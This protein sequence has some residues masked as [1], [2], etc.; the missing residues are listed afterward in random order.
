MAYADPKSIKSCHP[1]PIGL[2][3][4]HSMDGFNV[5]SQE[6]RMVYIHVLKTGGSTVKRS[7]F[8][9]DA[10]AHHPVGG[11]LL[12]ADVWNAEER[13]MDS[14]LTVVSRSCDHL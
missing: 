1:L 7:T 11:H 10:N 13:G 5:I 4:L 8:F 6:N 14:F 9:A 2:T 3:D 12:V